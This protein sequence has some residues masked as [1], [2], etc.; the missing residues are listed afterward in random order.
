MFHEDADYP[1]IV[2]TVCA[3]CDIFLPVNDL[4]LCDDCNAKL[5]RDLIRSRDWDYSG[6]AFGVP[7]E[8][9]E[10]LREQVIRDYGAGYE[11]IAPPN[12]LKKK[13]KNKRSNSRATQS[14]RE[15]AAKAIRNYTTEYVLQ[16]ARDF[17]KA[18]NEEWVNFSRLSQHLYE[19]FFK[20]K[21]KRLGQPGK[22]YKSLLKFLADYP[23]DFELRSDE[24]KKGLYWIRCRKGLG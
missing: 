21:P 13:R 8:K 1:E 16:V 19:T 18:S 23:D 20:L 4:G 3:G 6:M 11:L 14:K 2:D 10:A 12:T 15:I 22:K 17:L 9:Y 5:E 24:D 7:S